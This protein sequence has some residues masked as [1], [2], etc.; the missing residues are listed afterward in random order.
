MLVI[1]KHLSKGYEEAKSFGMIA[2]QVPLATYP[3]TYNG[4]PL[5]YAAIASQKRYLSLYLTSITLGAGRRGVRA[6]LSRDREA[7][8]RGKSCIRFRTVEAPPL[9][10]VG[11]VVKS[12]PV[13]QFVAE[14][15]TARAR[16]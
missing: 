12:R 7:V 2:Y 9:D 14:V 8:R 13:A 1:L 6:R 15:E 11:R 4:K 5:M 3:D 10:L 16:R